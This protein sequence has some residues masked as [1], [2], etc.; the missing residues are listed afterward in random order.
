MVPFRYDRFSTALPYGI[1]NTSTPAGGLNWNIFCVS[2]AFMEIL[3]NLRM[4]ELS[5]KS[6]KLT[7]KI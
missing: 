6:S 4:V 2:P 3:E 5:I 1:S 7:C